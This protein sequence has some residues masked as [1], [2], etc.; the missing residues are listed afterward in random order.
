MQ[1]RIFTEPQQGATYDE[2]LRV[3]KA[4]EDLG[5]EAFFRSDHYQR[6]GG[7]DPGAGSSDAWLTLAALARETSTIRLGTLVSPT[8]FRLPGPFAIGAAQV[9]QMSAGRVEIGLGSGWYEAEHAAYGIPFHSV[10]ERFDRFAEQVEIIDG[11]L[12]TPTGAAYS[13]VGEHY[14]LTDSPALPKPVQSPRPP[15][16]LGGS[17]KKRGA[18]LAATYA[19]EFNVP[20]R[21]ASDTGAVFDRVRA[22]VLTTARDVRYSAAQIVCIG[23]TDAD[24]AR[25]ANALGRSVDELRENGLAGSPAEVLDK[26]GSFADIGATRMYLQVLDLADLDHLDVI[27]SDVAAHL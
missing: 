15:F 3:A 25:R 19:D 4:S 22:A 16:V 6:I 27:A 11:L 7:G 2:I 5:F 1:L 17:G 8:T 24:V 21:S 12:R 26:L 13:F 18:L 9:D 10:R 14:R 23:R 20:F